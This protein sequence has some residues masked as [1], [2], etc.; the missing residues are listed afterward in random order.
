MLLLAVVLNVRVDR[1]RNITS[2]R[3]A[4]DGIA[5][6]GIANYTVYYGAAGSSTTQ[7]ERSVTVSGSENTALIIGLVDNV[8]YQFQVVAIGVLNGQEI[9]GER[10][11]ITSASKILIPQLS[12]SGGGKITF[13]L[14]TQ[15]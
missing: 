5:V 14:K 10:S 6:P 9:V 7:S 4:W 2:V 15:V 3:V 1:E 8:E 11:M 13:N 12:L